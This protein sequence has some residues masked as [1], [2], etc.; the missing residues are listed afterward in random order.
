[1]ANHLMSGHAAPT[2]LA[3]GART[4][5]R[6]ANFVGAPSWTWTF[7]SG[8]KIRLAY[9]SS[10]KDI[11]EYLGPRYSF[12]GFDESTLHSE[13]QI[14][15]MLGR[16]SS[17]DKNLRLRVRLASNPTS[18]PLAGRPRPWCSNPLWSPLLT[19]FSSAE[20][21]ALSRPR[22]CWSTL[23]GS[24]ITPIC[25]PSFSASSSRR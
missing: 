1:M 21:L 10:D 12:I 15:N 4:L 17:T 5:V 20:L 18:I 3:V 6:G 22:P 7:P 19:F 16:L 25:A 14:R 2:L 13:Y 24:P 23:L 9:I 8:A 11:W